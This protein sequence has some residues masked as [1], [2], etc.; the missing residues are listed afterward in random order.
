MTTY[1]LDRPRAP[2]AAFGN[3]VRNEARLAWRQPAGMIAG[4]GIAL[5]LLIIFGEIPHSDS[6]RPDWAATRRSTST[7]RSSCASRSR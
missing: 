4:T 3:I 6:P 5:L 1:A 2:R 7:S